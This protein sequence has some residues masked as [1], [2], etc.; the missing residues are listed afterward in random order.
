MKNFVR[1]AHLELGRRRPR[2]RK[3]DSGRSKHWQAVASALGLPAH[4]GRRAEAGIGL[5]WLAQEGLR[6]GG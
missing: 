2:I 3:R 6:L 1:Q 4:A 5:Q